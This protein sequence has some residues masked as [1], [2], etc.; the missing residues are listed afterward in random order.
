MKLLGDYWTLRII[1]ALRAS[2]VRF[3]ELQRSTDNLNPTT[4]TSRLKKL[5][6][7][8]LVSRSKDTVDKCSVTYSLT[9]LGKEVL[10]VIKAL[11][12]FSAKLS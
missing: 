11:D 10:P 3:C 5:E 6:A 12:H 8:R 1:D 4:L 7:A 9:E 2:E